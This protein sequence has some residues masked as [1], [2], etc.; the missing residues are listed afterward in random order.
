[1]SSAQLDMFDRFHTGDE[2]PQDWIAPIQSI[3]QPSKKQE[4]DTAQL[5]VY[6]EHPR[7]KNKLC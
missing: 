7:H 4:T 6:D 2:K 1:M 3:E 5:D